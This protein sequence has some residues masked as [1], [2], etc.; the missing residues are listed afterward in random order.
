MTAEIAI[1]NKIGVALAADSAISVTLRNAGRRLSVSDHKIFELTE[2]A[3]VA[4]LIHGNAEF[5][6]VPVETL[7]K[8]YRSSLGHKVYGHL[9]DYV[10]AFLEYLRNEV[11]IHVSSEEQTRHLQARIADI[12]EEIDREIY[13]FYSYQR[14]RG[15]E[16]PYEMLAS[17]V[18]NSYLKRAEHTQKSEGTSPQAEEHAWKS[19]TPQLPAIR[20]RFLARDIADKHADSLDRIAYYLI[21]APAEKIAQS[22]PGLYVGLVF[23]GFGEDEMFPSCRE[24]RLESMYGEMLKRTLGRRATITLEDDVSILPFAQ[25]DMVGLFMRGISEDYWPLVEEYVTEEL[26]EYTRSILGDLGHESTEAQE[27]IL[28]ASTDAKRESGRRL[29]DKLFEYGTMTYAGEILDVIRHLPEDQ[30]A[31]IA[32]ALIDLTS[33]RRRLSY[34]E[35][36]VGGP[37]DV[38]TITKGDGMRWVKRK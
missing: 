13:R 4:V 19:L 37:T 28:E 2:S 27:R 32:E 1:L 35:E 22:T 25:G 31:E 33:I 7:I 8:D 26:G 18:I 29:R 20:Q 34:D 24:I 6:A 17:A 5:M 9:D 12:Y 15:T 10:T 16:E 11:P 14:R 30:M 23:A 3:P 36:T 21:G 38:A